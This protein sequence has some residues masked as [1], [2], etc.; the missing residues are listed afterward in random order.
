MLTPLPA[1]GAFRQD[2]GPA[3]ATASPADA[4]WLQVVTLLQSAADVPAPARA[5]I[6]EVVADLA[7]ADS[8]IDGARI[9]LPVTLRAELPPTIELALRS[10][11]AME[12]AARFQLAYSS[13]DALL[14]VIVS[15]VPDAAA[16]AEVQGVLLALQGRTARHLG[17]SEAS[18]ERYEAVEAIGRERRDGAILGR[19]WVGYGILA[20]LRGNLPDARKW[21]MQ[22]LAERDAVRESQQVS[23]H[24][25][26]VLTATAGDFATA[27]RHGWASYELTTTEADAAT[28]LCDLSELMRMSGRPKLAL[29]GFTAALLR[30]PTAPR[31]LLPALGG[32]AVTAAEALQADAAAPLVASYARRIENTISMT[33]LPYPHAS[34]LADLGDAWAILGDADACGAAR[35]RAGEIAESHG[36][37]ELLYRVTEGARPVRTT[38]V[39]VSGASTARE[40]SPMASAEHVLHSIEGFTAPAEVELALASAGV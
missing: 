8:T 4:R 35:A 3:L 32:A 34:A 7:D 24:A 40:P 25:M 11:I 23:H 30:S 12:D 28:A 6:L 18:R 21:F 14:R 22:T 19:A 37:F 20:Q 36:F 5:G 31:Q 26:M 16:R 29:R 15:Q 10:A 2:L 17:D 1:L 33:N 39:S 9:P 38:G 13:Y 27:A